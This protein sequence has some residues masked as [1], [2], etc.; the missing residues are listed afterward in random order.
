MPRKVKRLTQARAEK[1]KEWAKRHFGLD[2]WN[3]SIECTDEVPEWADGEG[4]ARS[5]LGRCVYWVDEHAAKVWVGPG[6]CARAKYNGVQT[7]MHEMVHV[8]FGSVG[9]AI[10]VAEEFAID[11]MADGLACA[12]EHG[13]KSWRA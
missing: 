12:F 2:A 6:N 13:M 3:I 10:Q 1:A 4:Y 8:F 11:R 7:V 9:V 5:R